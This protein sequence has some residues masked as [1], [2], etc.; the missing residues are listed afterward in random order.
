MTAAELRDSLLRI[1]FERPVIAG[2]MED[3]LDILLLHLDR[4]MPPAAA[5]MA[6][7]RAVI[8][9]AVQ[10]MVAAGLAYE[11]V[12]LPPGALQCHWHLELTAR[13]QAAA[14]Q[15]YTSQR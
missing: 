11:P 7:R 13:G 8:A 15:S 2:T 12:R 4:D 14:Q 9:A 6:G 10:E 1:V 3:G 5:A